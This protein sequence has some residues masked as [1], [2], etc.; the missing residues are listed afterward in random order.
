MILSFKEQF[1]SSIISGEKVTTIRE[2]KSDRWRFGLTIDFWKGNPRNTSQDTY[3]FAVAIC[4]FAKEI[5]ID[6]EN[7]SIYF[8]NSWFSMEKDQAEIER[9]VKGDGFENPS[10]FFQFFQETYKTKMFRGKLIGWHNF[11]T[12]TKNEDLFKFSIRY[13]RGD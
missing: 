6:I 9:F 4:S 13:S 12:R 8:N 2:D 10:A 11:V 3:Q 1:V 5:L 7:Q